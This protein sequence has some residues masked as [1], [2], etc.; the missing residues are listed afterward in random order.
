MNFKAIAIAAAAAAAATS[1]QAADLPADIAPVDYVRINDAYGAGFFVLPGTETAIKIGGRVRVEARFTDLL[2]DEDYSREDNNHNFRSRANLRIDTRTQSELGLIRTYMD[3]QYTSNS[4]SRDSAGVKLDKGYVQIGGFT[5]GLATS[6]FDLWTGELAS[7]LFDR[8]LADDTVWQASYTH[9]L[10]NGLTI[11]ASIE[12]NSDRE[13]G[14]DVGAD[15]LNKA[16]NTLP[17][18]VAKVLLNQGWG[19][20]GLSG[21]VTKVDTSVGRDSSEV[22]YAVAGAVGFNL[23]MIAPGDVI[24]FQAAYA[25]GAMAYVGAEGDIA[26]AVLNTDGDI[27]TNKAW[28]VAGGYMHNWTSELSSGV[29][30]SYLDVESGE[31]TIMADFNEVVVA[32]TMEYRPVSGLLFSAGAGWKQKDEDRS[33]KEDA[34]V[35]NFRVQRSF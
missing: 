18:F 34:A 12:D 27:E 14:V 16:G 29:E 21:A 25:D 35:L 3:F 31:E 19:Y 5:F 24:N 7:N 10:G 20:A 30:A 9:A 26:D 33:S 23:D 4:D 2:D 1:V 32:G 11:A 8:H 13:Q 15:D 17:S 6:A 28:S 22:G